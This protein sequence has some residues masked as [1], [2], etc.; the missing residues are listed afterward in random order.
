MKRLFY[1]N[2]LIAGTI[3]DSLSMKNHMPP[4]KKYIFSNTIPGIANVILKVRQ[5]QS[6][7]KKE[8]LLYLIHV[9]GMSQDAAKKIIDNKS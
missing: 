2:T 8:E 1:L 6:L 5:M 7:T 4:K 9:K 3:N